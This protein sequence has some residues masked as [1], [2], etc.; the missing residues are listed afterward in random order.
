[1]PSL[2]PRLG[3]A[4]ARPHPRSLGQL[5][6]GEPVPRDQLDLAATQ[7]EAKHVNEPHPETFSLPPLEDVEYWEKYIAAGLTSP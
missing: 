1:M 6:R 2:H 3:I 4:Y 7:K 5:L